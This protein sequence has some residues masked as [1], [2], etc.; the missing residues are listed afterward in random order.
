MHTKKAVLPFIIVVLAAMLCGPSCL[1]AADEMVEILVE[2]TE[3]NNRRANELG[4]KWVDTFQAGELATAVSGRT[5]EVMPDVPS[6]VKSGEWSRYTPLSAELKVLHEKGAA[7]VLSKPRLLTRSGTS[8]HFIVGGEFPVAAVGPTTSSVEWK[9]YGIKTTIT[10]RVLADKS[11]DLTLSTEVSR[12]DW[13]NKVQ[14]YPAITKNAA[15]SSVRV[16]SEQTVTLA[17][18][19]ETK[20]EEQMVGIPLLCEI[21]VLGYLFGRKTMIDTKVNVLIFVTPKIIE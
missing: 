10:P 16:R 13:A 2:I 18:M 5:P 12:L 19:I 20:R 14:N 9:E 6:L 8:A 3:I 17:G 21:P 15:S 1:G 11:I 7:Q 4:I